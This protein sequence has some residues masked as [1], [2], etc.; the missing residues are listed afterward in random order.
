MCARLFS[1]S[2]QFRRFLF[3]VVLAAISSGNA[4]GQVQYTLT[5]LGTIPGGFSS[6]AT[7]IN[8]LGQV[9]GW[10]TNN[11]GDGH[12]FL[13][14]GGSMLDLGAGQAVGINNSGQVVGSSSNGA[15]I[16]NGGS[17]QN[18]GYMDPHA[19]N[20]LG[21][22]VGYGNDR[23]ALYSGGSIQNLGTLPAPYDWN[24]FAYG[25][26]DNGQVVGGSQ[27]AP[28]GASHAFLYTGGS[29]QDIGT[30]PAPY[31]YHCIAYDI[32]NL[33]Q[34]VGDSRGFSS[35]EHAFLYSGGSMLDLGA[36][37]PIAI[38]NLGQVLVRNSV[39]TYIYSG[40]IMQ[41][42]NSLIVPGSG[43]TFA[44]TGINDLG[45]IC[46]YG[47]NSSGQTHALL[48]TPTTTPEPPTISWKGGNDDT[49][50]AWG[51]A[52]NWNLGS[53]PDGPGANVKFGTQPSN[54][55][56]V[57]MVSVGRT[58]GN[59]TFAATTSTT[60]RST[61]GYA[62]TID[63]NG[64]SSTIDVTSNHTISAPVIIKNDTKIIGGGNLNLS[65]GIS[66]AYTLTILGNLTTA[67]IQVDT[68]VIGNS[69]ANAVPEPSI[70]TLL[71]VSAFGLMFF[72]LLGSKQRWLA[73]A[74][75]SR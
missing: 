57:D 67:S 42:L 60:I 69:G 27:H 18:I 52:N 71:G 4:R 20:D 2:R 36:G 64:A 54:C 23:A 15:F 50:T 63:N 9:V 34:I 17:V 3:C 65:G 40:G 32:N 7:D 19:I 55:P 22:V 41:N 39:D 47:T 11:L 37:S 56:I 14:S 21:Q 51:V 26:N 66:G 35:S 53:V 72:A 10:A 74:S 68:L 13:Y 28:A 75:K 43:C 48:L 1:G 44:A 25:V 45:Q 38:N 6:Q 29:M 49:S 31:D 73:N 33:G 58:V 62:L 70:L 24:S 5:D 16:Y 46:G 30:L 8:N 59:I 12:A 61:Y